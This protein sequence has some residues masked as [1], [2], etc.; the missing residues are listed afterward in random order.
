M[1]ILRIRKMSPDRLGPFPVAMQV[2]TQNQGLVCCELKVIRGRRGSS[3]CLAR[4]GLVILRGLGWPGCRW[5][6]VW[7][8]L[9]FEG[10]VMALEVGSGFCILA[11][12][13]PASLFSC[14]CWVCP[15]A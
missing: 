15:V 9:G 12:W 4:P 2:L 6:S 13:P 10:P 3:H 1:P 5:D 7:M 14:W 11:R 8:W